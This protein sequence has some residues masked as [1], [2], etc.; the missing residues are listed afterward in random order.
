MP[1]NVVDVALQQ[2]L[3]NR[4]RAAKLLGRQPKSYLEIQQVLAD[5]QASMF[6][7]NTAEIDFANEAAAAGRTTSYQFKPRRKKVQNEQ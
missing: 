5:E 3:E 6:E 1:N 7:R 4:R 2:A